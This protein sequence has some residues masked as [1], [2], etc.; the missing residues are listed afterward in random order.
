M[1]C[2]D[3]GSVVPMEIF[4]EQDSVLPVRIVLK[5]RGASE[6]RA[7]AGLIAKKNVDEP[8]REFRRHAIQR[9]RIAR[10]CRVFNG[11]RIA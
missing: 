3:A 1:A 6:D 8:S 2:A 11:I 7:P 9:D 10:A 5:I 4:I